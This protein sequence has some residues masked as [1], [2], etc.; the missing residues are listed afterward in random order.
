MA[1]K[2]NEAGGKN[3]YFV[4]FET[5]I[6]IE[7][8]ARKNP[9]CTPYNHEQK[10]NAHTYCMYVSALNDHEALFAARATLALNNQAH[11]LI[12]HVE[13]TE[14]KKFRTILKG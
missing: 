12:T 2:P 8:A 1:N 9:W 14:D 11:T 3:A 6:P 10:I 5:R 4:V 13:V 7:E